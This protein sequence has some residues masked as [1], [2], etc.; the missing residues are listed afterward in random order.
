MLASIRKFGRLPNLLQKIDTIDSALTRHGLEYGKVL[1]VGSKTIRLSDNCTN[2]D[3]APGPKVDIVGD[4]HDLATL[5]QPATFDTVVLSAVLQY[6]R[7]PRVVVQQVAEALKPNGVIAIDAPFLKPY[8]PDG[9][10]LWRFTADGLRELCREHFNVVEISAERLVRGLLR[11]RN[12]C[13]GPDALDQSGLDTFSRERGG[14]PRAADL[15][16]WRTRFFCV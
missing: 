16:R 8:C 15:A 9:A 13:G 3:I 7:D 10:D 1:N 12:S 6:C 4:A 11:L 14:A 2:L 5:F